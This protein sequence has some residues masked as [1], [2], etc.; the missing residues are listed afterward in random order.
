MTNDQLDLVCGM[1]VNPDQSPY[2][3][4]NEGQE[5]FFCSDA[6]FTWLLKHKKVELPFKAWLMRFSSYF[7]PTIVFIAILTFIN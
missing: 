1:K 4:N 3:F 7:V 5:Y 6:L 2:K